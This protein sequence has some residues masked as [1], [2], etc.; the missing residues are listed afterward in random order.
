MGF[1]LGAEFKFSGEAR[2][3]ADILRAGGSGWG[4]MTDAAQT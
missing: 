4:R 2:A 1:D 3:Q